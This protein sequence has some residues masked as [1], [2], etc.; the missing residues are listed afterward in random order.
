MIIKI[1]GKLKDDLIVDIG[2]SNQL[3]MKTILLKMML[4]SSIDKE[5][6]VLDRK[7]HQLASLLR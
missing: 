5:E 6:S 1:L 7:N 2:I 4:I 3:V